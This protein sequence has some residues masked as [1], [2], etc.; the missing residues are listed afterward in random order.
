MLEPP[1]NDP[2]PPP[3][4]YAYPNPPCGEP[5][6]SELEFYGCYARPMTLTEYEDI[7]GRV[8]FFDAR[9]GIA[10]LVCEPPHFPHEDPRYQLTCLLERIAQMRGA[11]I[12]CG[13]QTEIRRTLGGSGGTRHIHPDQMVFADLERRRRI[14]SPYLNAGE[15]PYPD[16]VLEV[17]T[18]TDVRENRLK[19]YE[20]WGFPEVWVEVPDAPTPGRRPGLR[21]GLRIHLLEAGR[22]VLSEES[23]AFP[24]WRAVEIHRALNE[25]VIS[26]ETSKILSRV[27]RAMG[28]SEGTGPE[29]D[30]LLRE[31]R[32]E[33]R[34]QGL[35]QG[36]AEER[37]G[38]ARAMLTS[39]GIAIS[40]DFPQ[41]SCRA[42]LAEASGA[43][44][45]SA[46]A[47][48]SSEPE[49]L[50]RLASD[51]PAAGS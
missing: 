45:V 24:G 41:P 22:Y 43:A 48:A 9:A 25:P 32:A 39:R 44:I 51:P 16:V 18:T 40:P 11:P 46:A 21:S 47:A 5:P 2:S 4:A 19:L 6:L 34:T 3:P 13:G 42:A 29:D 31:Q 23:R 15:D 38:F 33:G 30:P 27:G 1:R 36:R 49:F 35:A 20:A 50:A 12:V 37:A 8:E 17:D 26:E 10:W 28:E 7:E 14:V